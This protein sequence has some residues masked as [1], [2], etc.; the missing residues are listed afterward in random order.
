[1]QRLTAGDASFLYME[2]SVV[3]MHVTGM[4]LLDPNDIP[5]G[6]DY[7]KFR[8]HVI[9]R[10][11]LIEHFRRRLVSVPFG[12]DHP[13]WVDYPDFD[14]DEHLH[15]VTLRS[16][17]THEDLE[18]WVGSYA[19][20]PLDRAKPLWDMVLIDGLAEG[21]VA[22]VSKMHHVAVD[23][24]SGADLLVNLVDLEQTF[25]DAPLPEKWTPQEP[26]S[27]AKVMTDAVWGRLTDPLR[28][29]RA[30]GRTAEGVT[31]LLRGT[32]DTAAD[33]S[34]H[35]PSMARPF[36][37]PRSRLNSSLT[38]RRAVSI[39][40]AT[41]DDLKLVKSTFGATVND[42]FLAAVTASLRDY[43]RSRGDRC[44]K[45]L[46]CSVPV[47]VHGR[48]EEAGTTNQVSNMFVRLPVDVDDPVEQL[49]RVRS[50]TRD[51]KLVHGAL[52]ADVIGDVT[53]LTPPAIFNL[54]SRMY[55]G[56]RLAE[57]LP[58]IHNLIVS[59]VPGPPIPLYVAGARIVGVYPF[60]PLTEGSGLNITVLSNMGNMDIGV[61]SCPDTVPGAEDITRGIENALD[62]LVS[63]AR[64]ELAG[65]TQSK[66][67][68]AKK[69]TRTAT[70]KR[71]PSRKPAKRKTPPR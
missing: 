51:A 19:S 30:F 8:A 29:V 62:A 20:A 40:S 67:A 55:S 36:E 44:E 15:Q 2:N 1:M 61:I 63:A 58:P 39:G 11:H 18:T 60:G 69:A 45:P 53:E 10:L 24:V 34:G 31:N 48:S 3:H 59:N 23:G 46:V 42:V 57:R 47:S 21:R 50:D 28:T 22:L 5:G 38:A 64:A 52:A 17:G 68:T 54:A 49:M 32:P 6:Y 4:M 41:L 56:A 25:V 9:G 37:G 12:I 65:R 35:T 26:P 43:L 16:P 7:E 33:S 70:K 66:P 71:A 27:T 14:I 13:I